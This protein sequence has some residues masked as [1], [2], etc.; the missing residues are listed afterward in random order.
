M[1]NQLTLAAQVES[2]AERFLAANPGAEDFIR[3]YV[4]CGLDLDE[5]ALNELYGEQAS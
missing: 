4:S 5:A 3:W 1:S 2:E